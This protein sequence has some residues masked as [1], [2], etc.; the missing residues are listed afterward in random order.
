MVWNV[1]KKVEALPELPETET[2]EQMREK[3]RTLEKTNLSPIKPK[4]EV[5]KERYQVVKEIPL[6]RSENKDGSVLFTPTKSY[7]DEDTLIHFI[8]IEEALTLILNS[9]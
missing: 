8:T 3:I 2:I 7:Q 5:M 9:E 1:K 6:N 4:V